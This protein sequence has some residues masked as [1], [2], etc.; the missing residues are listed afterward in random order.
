MTGR[1]VLPPLGWIASARRLRVLVWHVHAAWLSAFVSGR[2]E[3]LIPRDASGGGKCGHDWPNAVEITEPSEVDVVVLQ[4]PEDVEAARQWVLGRPPMVYVE[5]NT[6]KGQPHPLADRDDVGF[7][8]RADDGDRARHAGS[9]AAL[10]RE[11]PRAAAVINEP[12]R[13]ARIVGTPDLAAELGK[14]S[15]EAALARYGLE[16]FLRDWD[17]L[18][19]ETVASGR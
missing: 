19:T 12:V 14:Q 15:R 6:P 10:H 2:H 5:H 17:W 18:L 8:P 11:L 13:R 1:V 9:R 16:P 4:R 3:Y 7:R